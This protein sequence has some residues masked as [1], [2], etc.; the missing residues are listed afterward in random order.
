MP[1]VTDI[2][3]EWLSRMPTRPASLTIGGD[4]ELIEQGL[5]DS[6]EILNLVGFLEERFA[7]AL[8]VEDFVPENFRTPAAV[9]ALVA[10][11]RGESLAA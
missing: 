9:A 11:L 7:I 6:V 5:L 8:P 4:T 1:S 3:A 2:V 10:R